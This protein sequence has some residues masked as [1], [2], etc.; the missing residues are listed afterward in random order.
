MGPE[1]H[2]VFHHALGNGLA[3][4]GG[5]IVG[6]KTGDH[7]I[8]NVAQQGGMNV[9]QGAGVDLDVLDAQLRDLLQHHVQ[10]IVAVA[11]MMMERNGHAVFQTGKF[12]GLPNRFDQFVH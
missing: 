2:R 9:K 6:G 10:H 7:V 11:E 5:N 1:F 12:N 4:T 3:H 8:F